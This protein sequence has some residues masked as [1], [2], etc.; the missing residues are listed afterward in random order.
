MLGVQVKNTPAPTAVPTATPF[1]LVHVTQEEIAQSGLGER[2]LWR[3]MEGED[4]ALMQ[5][6]LCELG[7]YLGEIDGVFGLGTRSAVYAFQRA[8]KME[9]VD[10]KVGPATIR[11]MF[12]DDVI[13]KPTPTPTPTPTPVPTP[14]PSPTPIP[15]P[16]P[17]P[18][19]DVS[20]APFALEQMEVYVDDLPF[21]LFVG[22]ADDGALLYPLCGVMGHMGYECQYAQGSWQLTGI[23]GGSQIALMTDGS[24]G[25]CAGAMGAVDGVIFLADDL[26]R[27]YV[28]GGEAYVT[29]ALLEKMDVSC[30]VVG[31]VPVIHR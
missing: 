25:L 2:I 5:R 20:G 11:A 23:G 3:G 7:Y 27:V 16:A 15:T 29:D 19:P 28:Y 18:T 21:E 30:L 26:A 8:H 13:V 12:S 4:V 31:G 1:E 9:K 6:R 14:T 22:R 17:T 10:G 24:D